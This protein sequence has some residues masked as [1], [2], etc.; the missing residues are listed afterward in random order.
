MK[1]WV[2]YLILIIS[3]LAINS[4]G[5]TFIILDDSFKTARLCELLEKGDD[6]DRKYDTY[7]AFLCYDAALQLDSS[8]HIVRKVAMS[9]YKRGYYHAC[10][11]ILGKLNR[12][13]IN[14][15]D[16]RLKY[17][18]FSNLE[19]V[20]SALYWGK[21]IAEKYPYDSD[22]IVKLAH[23]YNSVEQPDSALYYTQNYREKDS[24]NIFVNRQ[25]AFAFYQ[26]GKYSEAQNEYRK[27]LSLNDKTASV[28][29]YMGLCY[30]KCDSMGLAYDNLLEAAK[31]YQ[32]NQPHILSQLGIVCI[33]L[34]MS[35]EGIV[36]IQ[37]AISLLQPKDNLMFTLTNSIA[38]GYFKKHK[39]AECVKYLK[40]SMKYNE[41]SIYTL[42]RLA[43]V[44]GL[45]GNTA[46]ENRYYQEFIKKAE[47]KE[48][49]RE[50]LKNLIEYAK[51]RV[52]NI[53]E[54]NFFKGQIDQ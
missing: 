53:K 34:G 24:T 38:N 40:E 9:Q 5:N 50:S 33:D 27:L 45:M 19:I 3:G 54:E 52:R 11:Q 17:N 2:L 28:Y 47:S 1:Q 14:H 26:K 12:D 36:Y 16:M 43:Q 4:Y 29:Y 32:F 22:I 37:K 25:Q 31:L 20:D 10:A 49:V 42:Y 8:S 18:C 39:Y 21:T 44:Y 35:E 30:A 46:Q 13:S 51:D 23:H 48:K 6:Y 7:N 41:G 15:Q